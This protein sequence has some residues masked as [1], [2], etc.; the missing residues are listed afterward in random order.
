MGLR[1]PP[2]QDFEK[3]IFLHTL[4]NLAIFVA[5]IYLGIISLCFDVCFFWFA[6]WF[7]IIEL[8]F[9]IIKGFI[10]LYI[11]AIEWCLRP[12][13]NTVTEI[14]KM[15]GIPL[16]EQKIP[17]IS[18]IKNQQEDFINEQTE[19]VFGSD[20]SFGKIDSDQKIQNDKIKK[21]ENLNCMGK[22]DHMECK[23]EFRENE[24]RMLRELNEKHLLMIS[25]KQTDINFL[26]HKLETLDE[27]RNSCVEAEKMK[28]EEMVD[29]LETKTSNLENEKNDLQRIVSSKSYQLDDLEKQ[30]EYL[31]S[32][33]KI[34]EEKL[35]IIKELNE[36]IWNLKVDNEAAEEK[37]KSLEEQKKREKRNQ[38]AS[39]QNDFK[40]KYQSI[41]EKIETGWKC[42][43]NFDESKRMIEKLRSPLTNRMDYENDDAEFDAK[44]KLLTEKLEKERNMIKIFT[45]EKSELACKVKDLEEQLETT[46]SENSDI[47]QRLSDEKCLRA[48]MISEMEVE[49]EQLKN[50]GSDDKTSEWCKY[51]CPVDLAEEIQMYKNILDTKEHQVGQGTFDSVSSTLGQIKKEALFRFKSS[52][53]MSHQNSQIPTLRSSQNEVKK[54]LFEEK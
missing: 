47:K 45:G 44:L 46:K 10:T 27:F 7:G 34:K 48:K 12:V 11:S 21:F 29:L 19:L 24:K 17:E 42:G 33:L 16:E 2:S 54:T 28:L 13:I 14:L 43:N 20:F 39:M 31:E 3:N 51:G 50:K 4:V 5:N 26:Q 6:I 52:S 22:A 18:S 40:E 15:F 37:I 25:E 8:Y 38:E 49:I 9:K 30:K 35:L 41:I 36:Q 32:T 1:I 23:C 53:S